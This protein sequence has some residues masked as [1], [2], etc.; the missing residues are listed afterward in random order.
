M[1]QMPPKSAPH[2][3]QVGPGMQPNPQQ[4]PPGPQVPQP[5]PKQNRVTSVPKPVGIDPLIILQE[6]E[7]R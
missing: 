7:H 5:Q 2:M 3:Q 6:R 1:G 4:R